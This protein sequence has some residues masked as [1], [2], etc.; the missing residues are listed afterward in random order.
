[1]AVDRNPDRVDQA[2]AHT[3]EAIVLDA[4][5]EDE[6]QRTRPA[7]RDLCICAIGDESSEASILCTA[8]LRQLG[9]PRV[10]ARANSQLQGRILKLVGAHEVVNPLEDFGKRFADQFAFERLKGELPLGAD[11]VIAEIAL[12]EEFVGQTLADLKL[13]SRFALTVVA[14]RRSAGGEVKLPS[15]DQ[16]MESGDVV[17]VVARRTAVVRFL[18]EAE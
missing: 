10:V 1:L 8:L 12:P 3:A 18:G 17:V 6:L 13:P 16:R 2:A 9:A 14:T 7:D 5:V 11:L 15:P 4:S